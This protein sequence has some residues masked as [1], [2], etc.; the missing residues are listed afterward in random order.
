MHKRY[1]CCI[2]PIGIQG[3]NSV[4]KLYQ[5]RENSYLR[6]KDTG[7]RI[8]FVRE[9]HHSSRINRYGKINFY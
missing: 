9:N 4:T 7:S 6:E 8:P 2:F 1:Y 3:R 5:I